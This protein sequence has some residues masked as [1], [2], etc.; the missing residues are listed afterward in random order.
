MAKSKKSKTLKKGIKPKGKRKMHNTKKHVRHGKNYINIDNTGLTKVIYTEGNKSPK[1]TIFKWDGKY[2]GKNANIHM[3]LNVDGKKTHSDLKLTNDDLMKIL[4]A[5]VVDK[6][7]DKRLELLNEPVSNMYALPSLPSSHSS[8]M[9]LAEE[10]QIIPPPSNVPVFINE[11]PE[12]Q[13]QI[14]I[15]SSPSPSPS[16]SHSHSKKGK[17]RSKS[18]RS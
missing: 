14:M 13:D 3:N 4:S 12:E 6:P 10:P 15:V 11:M 8:V 17:K 2:D 9:I 1:K 16:P 18:Q 5:N 7:I